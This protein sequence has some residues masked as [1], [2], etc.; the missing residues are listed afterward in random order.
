MMRELLSI[1]KEGN[2]EIHR[3]K[4]TRL[5]YKIS[6]LKSK[7]GNLRFVKLEGMDFS[8]KDIQKNF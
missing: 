2:K 3:M 6:H 8:E 7:K 1:T 5:R 4:S